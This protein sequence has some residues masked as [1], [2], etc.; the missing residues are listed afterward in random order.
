MIITKHAYQ[1]AKERCGLNK[2]ALDRV[3]PRMLE[4]GIDRANTHGKLRKYL[5]WVYHKGY[6]TSDLI[7]YNQYAFIVCDD[8]LLTIY[9]IPGRLNKIT[10]QVTGG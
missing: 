3:M 10:Y 4:S 5:D 8:I 7:V 6:E 1:R 2:Q 9:H